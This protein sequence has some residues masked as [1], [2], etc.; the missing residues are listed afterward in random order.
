M[1]SLGADMT[2]GMLVEWLVKRGDPVK[3]GD[4]I[5]VIETQKGAIDMEVY[6]TGVIS[7]ILHQPV[8]TLPVG[9][10]MARVETQASDREVAA[11][12][13][14][15]IDTVAPQI[16]TAADRVAAIASPIVRKIAMGKSLDLT[17]IK[18]S[19]PKGAILLRDLP[20]NTEEIRASTSD[21]KQSS[22]ITKSMRAAIAA[23]MSKSKNEI[24]HFYQS[25]DIELGNAQEWLKKTN[26]DRAPEQHILLLALLLKAVAKT[27]TKYPDLNGFYQENQFVHAK[28]IHIGNVISIRQGGL[29]VPAI[30]HVDKLSVDETMQAIRDIS[31]RGRNGHLRSSELTDATITITNM[32][33]R[34][35]DTVFA[36]IYPPQVA[37]IGFGKIRETLQLVDA[38]LV[39]RDVMSVCLSADHRVIDGML[40]A[41]FLNALSKQLQKPE[42]L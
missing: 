5:A 35:T 17:A 32:G 3:R 26:E 39:S 28:E 18:G 34:G 9:T 15:Q 22:G 13:A 1:P 11:T 19:G 24:P 12:I 29:V 8:V 23:A 2:E 4:I 27:L 38:I 25:L 16:D 33:E 36:V 30:H 31:A 20:E 6:H 40:G 10:V 21:R 42:L 41:K 37:I 7:E 14:P